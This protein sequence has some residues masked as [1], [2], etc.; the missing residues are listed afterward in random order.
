MKFFT[1][2]LFY[3]VLSSNFYRS[4]VR[5]VMTQEI[6]AAI[7][8]TS[9]PC[10]LNP[11]LQVKVALPPILSVVKIIDPLAGFSKGLHNVSLQIGASGSH[12]P[13]VSHLRRSKPEKQRNKKK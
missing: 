11:S 7:F 6:Y 8:L 2:I 13:L 3:I 9:S 12:L 1:K 5:Y 10:R 4:T